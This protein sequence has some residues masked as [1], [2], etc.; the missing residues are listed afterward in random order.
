MLFDFCSCLF[1][2]LFARLL[3]FSFFWLLFCFF[4]CL[5]M[6]FMVLCVPSVFWICHCFAVNLLVCCLFG[7]TFFLFC[8]VCL[9]WVHFVVVVCLLVCFRFVFGGDDVIASV[10]IFRPTGVAVVVVAGRCF[11]ILFK[12]LPLRFVE[13]VERCCWALPGVV[14]VA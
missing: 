4:A 11:G 7:F 8:L 1:V 14:V 10:T 6:F 3:F 12:V 2:C 9:L 5:L 13:C